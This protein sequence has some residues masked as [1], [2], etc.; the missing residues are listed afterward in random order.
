VTA[1]V[2]VI[3]PAWVSNTAGAAMTVVSFAAGRLPV[4]LTGPVGVAAVDAGFGVAAVEAGFRAPVRVALLVVVVA[5]VRPAGLRFVAAA[6]RFVDAAL[7][8]VVAGFATVGFAADGAFFAAVVRGGLV[9]E[10]DPVDPVD[11]SSAM[12]CLLR[13]A[14][15]CPP[16]R[17]CR[18]GEPC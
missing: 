4:P 1:I 13:C 3:G 2:A 9:P 6:F 18:R 16:R 10:P 11:V 15:H 17:S 5:L 12:A 7:R 14:R 8:R